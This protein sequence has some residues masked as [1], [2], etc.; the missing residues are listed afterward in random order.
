MN[1][2]MSQI[3]RI[4]VSAKLALKDNTP[5]VFTPAM[6]EKSIVFQ[7]A[8]WGQTACR[9][10]TVAA[11]FAECRRRGL[12]DAQFLTPVKLQD[13]SLLAF[14]NTVPNAL[15]C[16]YSNGRVTRFF[17]DWR[18]CE[19]QQGWDIT[20]SE[21]IWETPPQ[22]PRFPDN[23]ETFV[24]VLNAIEELAHRLE[25]DNFAHLFRKA[26]LAATGVFV[27][28][29]K[30]P[31]H[32]PEKNYRLFLAADAASVFGGMGSWNDSPP[33]VAQ[34]MNLGKEYEQLSAALRTQLT[35]AVL[36]AVNEW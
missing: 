24:R 6:Y 2:E 31:I 12:V 26:A 15:T 28:E 27:A 34:E 5:I 13:R 18:Y 23:T 25:F 9:T 32:L 19:Y 33:Y 3:C 35:L 30:I 21:S 4:V 20:Y 22:K 17:A 8:D 16:Y 11:W 7:H 1:G 29:P 14:V 10:D 36:Y